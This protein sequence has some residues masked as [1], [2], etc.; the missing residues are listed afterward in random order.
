MRA[1][2][3][4]AT[5]L[6]PTQDTP[7]EILHTVLLGINK[8]MWHN[9][10]TS[11]STNEPGDLFVVRLQS[12]DIDGLTVPPIRAAYIMQ[13]KNNLIGKHFKTLMQTMVFHVHDL[14]TPGQFKLIK[15]IG[16][17]GALLWV[18]EIDNMEEYL[19]RSCPPIP[20]EISQT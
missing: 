4:S 16:S 1:L 2:T 7:V 10:T 20:L 18:P 14:V 17:L 9:V 13:Y 3:F 19:V 6:D 5:G 15:A 12:T 11:W 8:Y